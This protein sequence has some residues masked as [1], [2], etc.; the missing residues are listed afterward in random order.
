VSRKTRL[1]RLW[2]RLRSSRHRQD[3]RG[4]DMGMLAGVLGFGFWVMVGGAYI[5]FLGPGTNGDDGM[6]WDGLE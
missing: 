2:L 5:V 4:I 1:L 6:R 3:S